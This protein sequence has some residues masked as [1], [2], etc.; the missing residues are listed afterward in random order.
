MG[1]DCISSWS[2]LIF[3]LRN[4]F[5]FFL[6]FM[7]VWTQRVTC[8]VNFA[9]DPLRSYFD[10]PQKNEIYLSYLHFVFASILW[11][12]DLNLANKRR[13]K[14]IN[15]RVWLFYVQQSSLWHDVNRTLRRPTI[16]C[17][18]LWPRLRVTSRE[19]VSFMGVWTS[20]AQNR[21]I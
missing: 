21:F 1:S 5:H 17:I 13:R 11:N 9:R 4:K 15:W 7:E 14:V 3:Y 10:E 20:L 12:F 2:L 16:Y 8:T 18:Y 6:R 19:G